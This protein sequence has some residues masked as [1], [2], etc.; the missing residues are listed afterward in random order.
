MKTKRI[1]KLMFNK[2]TVADL[3]KIEMSN[4]QGGSFTVIPPTLDRTVCRTECATH[5]VECPTGDSCITD[6]C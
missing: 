4:A 2:S 3:N 5:C 1:S 6:E